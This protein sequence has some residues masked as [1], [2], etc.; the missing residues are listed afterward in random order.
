MGETESKSRE[1]AMGRIR[2]L[3]QEICRLQARQLREIAAYHRDRDGCHDVV[4]EV[5]L[6]LAIGER[7]ARRQVDLARALVTRLPNTL[8]AMENGVIDSHKAS[9]IAEPTACLTDEKAR[10]V[11]V[12][13]ADRIG[14]R[15][16]ASI[17]RL[18]TTAVHR[19]DPDGA[20]ERAQRRRLHRR[21]ELLP[22]DDGMATLLAHL[23]AE[24]AGAAYARIDRHARALRA[25]DEKRTTDQLRADVLA[26]LLLGS[27]PGATATKAEVFVHVDLRTLMELNNEPAELAG[28]GPIPAHI[29]RQIAMEPTSVWRRIVTD[30][31]TGTPVDAGRRRYRPPAV[32]DD[33]V[34]VR[35]RECR[36][37]GCHR[38]SQRGDL[39]HVTAWSEDGRTHHGNLVGL[40][41]R[42]HRLKNAPG[43]KYRFDKYTHDLTITTPSGHTHTSPPDSFHDPIPPPR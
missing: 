42:H 14:G 26:D 7:A 25:A 41:R 15:D 9:K 11:D 2:S 34:R 8:A 29:A 17:R 28:Y 22:G 40:C 6:A 1:S 33:Y 20:A 35:D 10:Q 12:L 5:A 30:P 13:L 36:F 24:V 23:P 21:V 16:P 19:V 27:G 39:D 4:S 18:A 31:L 43:W 32:T 38:P 37:P 3:Q